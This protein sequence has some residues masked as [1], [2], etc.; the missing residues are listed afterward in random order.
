MRKLASVRKIL[1]IRP[2]PS[3]EA[4]ECA[5]VDGWTVVIKKGEFKQGDL[6]VYCEIDSWIPHD[7]APF[8]SKG[9]QPRE[10]RDVRGER[11]GTIKMRGQLSQGLLLPLNPSIQPIEG[12][13]VTDQLGILKY[14]PVIRGPNVND[15]LAPV[16]HCCCY[17]YY[18]H[19]Y[20]YYYYYSSRSSCPRLTKSGS[21]TS[22]ESWLSG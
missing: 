6:A 11:L 3:A 5:V 4:I 7:L 22:R 13:D 12:L 18:Y 8:L 16:S 20:Y 9:E 17:Y 21:R 10:Y 15:E 19:Y 2:I 14:V 1:E